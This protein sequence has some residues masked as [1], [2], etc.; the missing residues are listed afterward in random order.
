[1][2]RRTF[3]QSSV[4]VPT[5]IGVLAGCNPDQSSAPEEASSNRSLAKIG[6]QLYTVRDRLA[7]DFEGTIQAIADA[8][9]DEV[10]TVWDSERNPEDIRALLEQVGLTAPST[11]AAIETLQNNLTPVLDAA[12]ILGHSYIVCPWL[13]EDQR[14]MADYRSHVALFNEV[15]AACNELGITFA[16]H[17]HEFEFEATEEGIIPYDFM[18]AEM[19]PD[20]VQMELDLYWI[21]YANQD[22]IDYFQKHPGRFPLCHVKDMAADRSMTPVGEGQIDFGRIFAEHE[23]A[24]LQHYIVEHDHPEDA[25]SSIQT[26]ITHLRS[27]TF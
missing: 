13:D 9:Y 8:G 15:G 23:T 17:N 4:A 20:L 10:E 3:L 22:P 5:A 2:N 19:D 7:T 1:M 21:A 12:Q 25:L 24:G 26:S 6:V 16:Y 27:L 18:L 14:S 11:H